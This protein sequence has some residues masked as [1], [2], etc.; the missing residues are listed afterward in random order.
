M[1]LFTRYKGPHWTLLTV[2]AADDLPALNIPTV[3]IAA[4]EAYGTGIFLIRPDGYVG[5]AGATPE[6]LPEYAAG[7]GLEFGIN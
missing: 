7:L 3:R 2:D 1:H 6:G 4:Y 5:W